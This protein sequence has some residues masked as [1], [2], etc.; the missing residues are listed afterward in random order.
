MVRV[1]FL[2]LFLVLEEMLSAFTV[3]NEV[4]CG[5]VIFDFVMLRYIPSI[6]T[7]LR[8]VITIGY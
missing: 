4:S 8:I 3:D 6:P 1:D 5:L 7:L 2:V